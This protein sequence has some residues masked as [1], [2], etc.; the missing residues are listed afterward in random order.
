MC[1][2]SQARHGRRARACVFERVRAFDFVP[3][4]AWLAHKYYQCKGGNV[5]CTF[6]T[7]LRASALEPKIPP[8]LTKIIQTSAVGSSLI[9]TL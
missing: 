1:Q 4:L 6:S 5:M 8:D 7:S 2:W 9:N 3:V